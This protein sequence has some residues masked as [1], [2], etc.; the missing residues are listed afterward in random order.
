MRLEFPVPDL[1]LWRR[2]RGG[3]PGVLTLTGP[4]PGPHAAIVAL[5]H[6]NELAGAAALERLVELG[7]RPARGRLTLCLAN[8]SAFDSFDP[9]VP[10]RARF[11]DEDMNR[12]WADPLLDAPVLSRERAR[13]RQLR[14]LMREVDF[15]LD[16]HSMQM[17]GEPLLLCAACD[18]ARRFAAALGLPRTV[19]TDPGHATGPRLID[20]PRFADPAS[21]AVAVLLEAGPHGARRSVDM[22]LV[23][24]LRFLAVCGML[25]AEDRARL[26]LPAPPGGQRFVRIEQ[27]VRVQHG[28]LRLVEPR[29]SFR[30]VPRAGTT[31]AFDG[32][33]A[34]RTP[35][36][37]CA[38]VLPT[39]H[40]PVGHT[41]LRLGRLEQPPAITQRRDGPGAR[42]AARR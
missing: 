19:V 40:A 24:A 12:L 22:A 32:E 14:P 10:A 23:V 33:M 15:L 9:T 13:A 27:A 30:I 21:P 6:G 25:G 17:P 11:L 20:Y 16:L 5:V 1:S 42:T 8:L 7:I 41:A 2:G 35:Y 37:A 38:V 34:I 39:C 28:P 18:K 31:I 29:V 4:R 3:L 36:D 26:T